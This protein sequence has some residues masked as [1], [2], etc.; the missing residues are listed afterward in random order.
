MNIAIFTD[1]FLPGVGGT[2]KAVLGFA[3]E[4]SKNNNVLLAC[5]KY[6]GSHDDSKY[7]FKVVRVPNLR[8]YSGDCLAFPNLSKKLKKELKI[9][10]PDILHCQTVSPMAG[11]ALKYGKNHNIPV[12]MTIHTR[13][14]EAFA[15]S[16]KSKS[17]VDILIKDL[18]KKCHKADEVA[19]VCNAMAKELNGYGYKGNAIVIRNGTTIKKEPAKEENSKL[20]IEKYGLDKSIPTLLFV[21][22]LSSVK[23][24]DFL[25]KVF[26]LLKEKEFAFKS[27]IVGEGPELNNLT[28]ITKEYGLE[29]NVTYTG[30]V[31]DPKLLS[32][33]YSSAD[34]FTFASVFDNDPLVVVESACHKTPTIAIENTGS[35]ERLEN[36]I[37]GY[38]TTLKEEKFA[39]KIIEIFKDKDTLLKVNENAFTSVPKEWSETVK[40]YEAEYKKLIEKKSKKA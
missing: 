2:E 15:S 21:G 34:L 19:T 36:N 29:E 13:F 28:K 9:F 22:R 5:P 26:K 3:L 10:K 17:I 39:D 7:P 6:D 24:I 14:R 37:S 11:F 16:I 20:S 27:L 23:R 35:A 30:V 8:L 31:T 33:I 18:V 1:S 32:S 4:L 38:T 25:L 12:L 40:E